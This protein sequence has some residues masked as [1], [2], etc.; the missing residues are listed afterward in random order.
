MKANFTF[1]ITFLFINSVFGQSKDES[2]YYAGFTSLELVDKNRIYKPN[3]SEEDSLHYRPVDIDVWYPSNQK[4]DDPLL[5]G[6]M[7]KLFEQR[8]VKY[9][10]NEDYTGITNELAQFYVAELGIGI[11]GQKLLNI[12]TDSYYN[13]KNLKNELPVIIYMAGFNGMGF[14]NYKV[15]E[16]LAQSGYIVVSIWSMGRYPGNMTNEMAD[17]MEQVYDAEFAIK[18]LKENSI[19]KI[20]FSKIGILGCSWGGMSAGVLVERNPDIQTMVSFDG[21]EIH[22]LGESYED[23]R[24]LQ[25][26]YDANLLKPSKQNIKYLYF[27]SGDKLNDYS[28]TSEYNYYKKLNSEKEYLRFT[29]SQHSD[30]VC[31]PSILKSSTESVN[32]HNNLIKATV[33]FFNKNLYGIN[34]SDKYWQTLKTLN[35]TTTQLYDI[36]QKGKV[37]SRIFGEI[38]DFKSNEPL[39]YVNIGILNR[40]IGTVSDEKGKFNLLLKEEFANDTIRVSMVGYKPIEILV[41]NITGNNSNLSLTLEQQ[42][43]ELDEVVIFAKSFKKKTL[44]NKT[45]SKFLSTGFS[46]DQLGA[47]MGVKINIRKQPTFVETFN[48]NISYNRLSSKSIFRLNFYNLVK[49]KP[50]ENIL[51]ENILVPIE[52]KETGE[53]TIDLEKYD[54]ILTDDVIVTLEW[55]DSE[56]ENNKGEAIFFSL[57]LLTSGTIYKKTSQGK[58]K[59]HSSLGVGFNIDV[60]Y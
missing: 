36:D 30:F 28:P 6:D 46:Y 7:F 56:G 18:Y 21:T 16:N 47:E 43:G 26:I 24:L 29:N 31:I 23:D 12:K 1:I 17:M 44:G 20:D 11:D 55:I 42:V 32:I 38:V 15:L 54:I 57:G 2:K 41:K 4:K 13:L 25:E 33:D 48:F 10:D 52:P 22:Y 14:E 39:S 35:Y 5:F 19:F 60:R 53:I 49:G 9:Q 8:A 45:T 34:I 37:S 58:Y 59:K 51:K 27:E 40:E 50:A 3:T